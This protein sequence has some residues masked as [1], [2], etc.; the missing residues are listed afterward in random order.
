MRF[1]V[2]L[3]ALA[4]A[5]T[6]FAVIHPVRV[7]GRSME[8]TLRNG[9]VVWVLRRWLT[10]TPRRHQVWLVDTPEGPSL[11]RVVGLPGETLEQRDGDLWLEGRRMPDPY[12][13]WAARETAG[14]WKAEGGYL[15][16]GDNRPVSRDSRAWGTLGPHQLH[17]KV[18]GIPDTPT[19]GDRP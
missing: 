14:P 17:G 19:I 6:P 4:L 9:Q 7:S 8:P 3:A 1:W 13:T 10:G 5:F 15:V 2:P 18:L 12:V 16:V 11:K